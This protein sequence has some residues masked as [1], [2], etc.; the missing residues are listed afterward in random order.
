ME[1]KEL[2]ITYGMVFKIAGDIVAKQDLSALSHDEIASEVAQLALVLAEAALEGQGDLVSNNSH[3]VTVAPPTK[4]YGKR[5]GG[6]TKGGSGGPRKSSGGTP[7]IRDP[8]APA[9]EKQVAL[10]T[11]LFWSKE[12]DLDVDPDSFGTMTKGEISDVIDNL[13]NA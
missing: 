11:R 2:R 13:V 4:S 9:T 6:F 10:A 5:P 12:H 7:V 1:E 3:L 8:E